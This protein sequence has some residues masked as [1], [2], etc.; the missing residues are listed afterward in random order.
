MVLALDIGNTDT[1]IGFFTNS[2]LRGKAEAI[3]FAKRVPTAKLR[4]FLSKK[5][6]FI[7]YSHHIIISSVVPSL[8]KW[9]KQKF[10]KAIFI[11]HQ[12]KLPI[13]LNVDSPKEVGADRIANNSQ[14]FVQHKKALLVIDFGTAT[15][16]DYINTKGAY[17]G[18]VIIPGFKISA[19]ALFN[20]AQKLPSIKFKIPKKILGTNTVSQM[21]SGILRGYAEMI[22]GLIKSIQ[23]EVGHKPKIIITGGLGNLLSPLLTF[24]HHFDSFLTLKGLQIL[25]QMNHR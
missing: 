14:A 17:V 6:K 11:S 13:S 23:K 8:E 20:R 18:G 9:L 5:R 1:V 21:Q 3:S 12:L 4:V 25:A 7:K 16:I 15:T 10:K 22:N 24:P 19:E 2:S